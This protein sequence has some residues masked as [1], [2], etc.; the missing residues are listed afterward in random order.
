M[1]EAEDHRMPGSPSPGSE[2]DEE[3]EFHL[4]MRTEELEAEGLGQDEARRRAETEFGDLEAT[5]KYCR[6][7]DRLKRRKWRMRA[8]R[9]Q[10]QR[11]ARKRFQRKKRARKGLQRS[12]KI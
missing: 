3:L 7:Q 8:T 12:Q 6:R 1:R 9:K 4:A 10:F 5:R 2:L 11:R